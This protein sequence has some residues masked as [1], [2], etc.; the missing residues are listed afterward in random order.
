MSHIIYYHGI[1]KTIISNR[2]SIFVAHFWEQLHEYL[3]TH[4]IRSSAYY[5]QMD[6]QIERVNK[7]IEDMLHTYVLNDCPN[8]TSTFH[9]QSSPTTTVTKRASRCHL[10]KH[11]IDDPAAHHLVGP[12]QATGL[13]FVLIL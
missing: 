7:I 1:P 10:S 2:G 3:S 8:G 6:G 12:S 5:P 11:F 9:Y 13:S 4:L